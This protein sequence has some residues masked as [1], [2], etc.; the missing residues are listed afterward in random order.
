MDFSFSEKEELLRKSIAEFA[1]REIA[2]LVDKMEAEGGF[3]PELIPKLGEMGI[4][5]II[6]PTEYGGNGMGHVA[7]TIAVE[8]ISK[9]CPGVGLTLEGHYV[10]TYLIQTFG[11]EDQKKKYLPRLT[12]GETLGSLAVTEPT[13]GSDV[14]GIQTMARREGDHYVITGR[15]CFISNSHV[16]TIHATLARTGEG[17]KD[18]AVF[19]VENSFPGFSLGRKENKMGLRGATTGEIILD[20][21]QVPIEN[22]VGEEGDGVKQVLATINQA[23]RP[24]MAAVAVGICYASLEEAARFARERV[25]YG[26]PISN[27]Q[28]IQFLLAD[29]YAQAEAARLLTY[30][31]ASLLDQGQPADIEA[32]MAKYVACEA[33]FQCARWAAD[34]HGGYSVIKEYPIERLFRDAWVT[35][36]SSGTAQVAK[37]VLGR[38]AAKNF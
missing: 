14:A 26:K 38:Y 15:K 1:K 20:N 13:G 4:L 11:S 12:S 9:V 19:I 36:P 5:G 22:L 2:P 37:V 16:A 25:L 24:S 29:I 17:P 35:I 32:T 7:K 10:C 27:L 21:C 33:A 8:E 23:A 34:I 3:A 31:A 30:R 18:F 6:T 28:A